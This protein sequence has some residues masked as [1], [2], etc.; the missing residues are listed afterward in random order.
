MYPI[1][2]ST[3]GDTYSTMEKAQTVPQPNTSPIAKEKPTSQPNTSPIAKEKPMS[4]PSTSTIMDEKPTMPQLNCLGIG[5]CSVQIIQDIGPTN[6]QLGY[7]LL[8]DND[9]T[10]MKSIEQDERSTDKITREML[11]RWLR[12]SKGP[13]SWKVLI[14]TLQKVQLNTLAEKIIETLENIQ[15][16]HT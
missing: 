4:Q 11:S 1:Y 16:H 3:V 6:I 10:I 15:M 8:N 7:H 12:E 14:E 2:S 9:G 5:K 13:V